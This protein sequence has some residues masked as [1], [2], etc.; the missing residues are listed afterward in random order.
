MVPIPIDHNFQDR[1][2]GILLLIVL[3]M[4][5]LMLLCYTVHINAKIGVMGPISK[6]ND[7]FFFIFPCFYPFCHITFE[8]ELDSDVVPSC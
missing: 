8:I 3:Q 6:K 1:S 7:F 5:M 4:I 2:F